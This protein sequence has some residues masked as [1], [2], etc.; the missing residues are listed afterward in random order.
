[1]VPSAASW[2]Y[3]GQ[4]SLGSFCVMLLNYLL[5]KKKLMFGM[6]CIVYILTEMN[7]SSGCDSG[8]DLLINVLLSMRDTESSGFCSGPLSPAQCPSV[9]QEPTSAQRLFH[10]E[11]I[12][13]REK[14]A[15]KYIKMKDFILVM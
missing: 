11:R 13:E 9:G 14:E 7:C 10:F 4:P 15:G 3:P 1:M 5:L 2:R 8:R 6:V 12:E